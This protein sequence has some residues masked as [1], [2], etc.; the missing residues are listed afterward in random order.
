[1]TGNI[2]NLPAVLCAIHNFTR[3]HEPDIREPNKNDVHINLKIMEGEGEEADLKLRVL[4][5]AMRR[6]WQ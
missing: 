1:M 5:Q 6:Q 3:D 4:E 2:G